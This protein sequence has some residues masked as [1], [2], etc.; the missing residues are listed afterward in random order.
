MAPT[1]KITWVLFFFDLSFTTFLK[2]REHIKTEIVIKI[3][4]EDDDFNQLLKSFFQDL[5]S[6]SSIPFTPPSD[7]YPFTILEDILILNE[8][9][10][11]KSLE[12]PDP[13]STILQFK[14]KILNRTETSIRSRF[15]LLNKFTP[16][17]YKIMFSEH[18]RHNKA[19]GFM[20]LEKAED[21]VLIKSFALDFNKKKKRNLIKNID[22]YDETT[23]NQCENGCFNESEALNKKKSMKRK[24]EVSLSECDFCRKLQK[25]LDFE[26]NV[27][28]P[29]EKQEDEKFQN[30][31]NIKVARSFIND[32]RVILDAEEEEF[33]NL[34]K[35]VDFLKE[36]FKLN[37]SEIIDICG[38]VSGTMSSV[39]EYLASEENC[40]KM[41][42]WGEADDEVLLK[43]ESEKD[44]NFR[45]LLQYKG[46][47]RILK[48]L[49]FKEI[50]LPFKFE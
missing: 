19:E 16:N 43:A 18:L 21:Q 38:K 20:Y 10:N 37:G 5:L 8:I 32:Q 11:Q 45:L 39:E 47:E 40:H 36:K 44:L 28:W 13:L 23:T 31:E 24:A 41:M 48:R 12:S 35:A 9:I 14:G 49:K 34:R 30:L 22:L 29:E 15:E 50:E 33:E 27:G 1:G 26:N 17:H 4:E 46:K 2:E 7:D 42:V 3:K 6:K 25:I